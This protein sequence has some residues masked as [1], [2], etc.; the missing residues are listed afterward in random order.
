MLRQS[1]WT[2]EASLPSELQLRHL[3]FL[4][5]RTSRMERYL[6][7]VPWAAFLSRIFS[8]S[9]PIY[10]PDDLHHTLLHSQIYFYRPILA[11]FYS[12]KSDPT[13][14]SPSTL[15]ERFLRECARMCVNAVQTVSSLVIETLEHGQP[16][17]FLPWWTWIFYLHIAGVIFSRS[18]RRKFHRRIVCHCRGTSPW[19]RVRVAV[20]MMSLKILD[21][22]LASFC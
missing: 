9:S 7:H 12:M 18:M 21:W 14:S 5:D 1:T 13:Q 17:S 20:S 11:H 4:E 22:P 2:L 19:W 16:I 3:K 15:N 8:R 6:Y 10:T